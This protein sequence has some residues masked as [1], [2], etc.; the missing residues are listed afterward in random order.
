[1]TRHIKIAASLLLTATAA[2]AGCD[3][4]PAQQAAP[5]APAVPTPTAADE[6]CPTFAITTEM[7]K[8]AAGQV[9]FTVAPAPAGATWNWSTAAGSITSGQGTTT[10]VVEDKTPGDFVTVTVQAGNLDPSCPP[11]KTVASATAEMP[12]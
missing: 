7:G 2:L 12:Q 9:T 11:E 3:Q 5:P 1:M 10:I 4:K 6:K 8:P